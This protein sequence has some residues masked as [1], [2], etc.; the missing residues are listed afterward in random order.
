M[1]DKSFDVEIITPAKI[2][3]SGKV[4]SVSVPGTKS[5]FQILYNHAPIVSSLEIGIISIRDVESH[6]LIFATSGGIVEVRNNKVSILV[7]TADDAH[8]ID[9]MKTM[10]EIASIKGKITALPHG[11]DSSPLKLQLKVL[12]NN[13]KAA[14]KAS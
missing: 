3:Y 2:L 11:E 12:E 6:N 5:P 7:E 13:L 14:Q 10:N 9:I 8:S 4:L 1:A